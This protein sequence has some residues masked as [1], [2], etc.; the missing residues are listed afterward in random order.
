MK[1]PPSTFQDGEGRAT[2]LGIAFPPLHTIP[3]VR[4]AFSSRNLKKR[5][6]NK[7]SKKKKADAYTHSHYVQLDL[8]SPSTSQYSSK[9]QQPW[10]QDLVIPSHDPAFA[11][12][13]C[14]PSVHLRSQKIPFFFFLLYSTLLREAR[15]SKK[16][17]FSSCGHRKKE[18]TVRQGSHHEQVKTFPMPR[19][20]EHRLDLYKMFSED[21]EQKQETAR[22][23][24][25]K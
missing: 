10:G 7:I 3:T 15:T 19:S 24:K 2:S 25:C 5:G 13:F 14:P 16:I 17:L 4:Y 20:R 6:Q 12:L 9:Q 8:G 1:V 22:T 18:A 11:G 23:I 21:K